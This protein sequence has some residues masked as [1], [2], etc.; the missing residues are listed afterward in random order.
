V[1]TAVGYS[2]VMML[3]IQPGPDFTE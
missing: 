1:A 3:L 2:V